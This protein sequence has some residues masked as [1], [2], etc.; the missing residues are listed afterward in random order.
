[1]TGS[2]DEGG[3]AVSQDFLGRAAEVIEAAHYTLEGGRPG[4]VDGHPKRWSAAASQHCDHCMK[5]DHLLTQWPWPKVCPVRL[6]LHSGSGFKSDLGF[7]DQERPERKEE[8]WIAAGVA[9]T[10]LQF[11]V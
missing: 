9:I 5:F 3:C 10:T 2:D 1:M 4:L 6:S 11:G 7:F 8:G